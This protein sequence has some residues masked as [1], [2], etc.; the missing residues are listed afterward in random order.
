M[1]R[2]T[3][4]VLHDHPDQILRH[5]NL[6]QPGD[7]RVH[8]LAVVMYL[9]GEIGVILL[10]RLEHDLPSG[11][12]VGQPASPPSI[13]SFPHPFVVPAASRPTLDPLVSL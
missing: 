5:D 10:G 1:T 8:E 3:G 11:E 9:A 12:S 13:S 7:V 6:V 4:T 2:P